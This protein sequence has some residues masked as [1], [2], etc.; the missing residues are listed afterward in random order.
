MATWQQTLL[1]SWLVSIPSSA[2]PSLLE[3]FDLADE[4]FH[5]F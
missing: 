5:Y 2:P 3:L 1:E 4:L